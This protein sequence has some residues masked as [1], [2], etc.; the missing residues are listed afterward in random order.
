[1]SDEAPRHLW[2]NGGWWV[3]RDTPSSVE[4]WGRRV[5]QSNPG[6]RD[7]VRVKKEDLV[8]LCEL[9]KDH[10]D[11]GSVEMVR[12][13]LTRLIREAFTEDER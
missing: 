13:D 3:R 6:L 8:R 4:E 11:A 9:C 2:H 7:W 10:E 5:G 12:E 1:M